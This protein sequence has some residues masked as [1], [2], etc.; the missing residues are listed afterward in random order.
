MKHFHIKILTYSLIY[1]LLAPSLL[2]LYHILTTE[3]TL[4]YSSKISFNTA[5][6]S[7]CFVFHKKILSS[8][9]YTN[10]KV[11]YTKDIF[12]ELFIDRIPRYIKKDLQKCLFLRA[13]PC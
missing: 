4:Q 12:S 8:F 3:H 6:D 13:P 7:S 10:F 2:K 11:F 9:T 5:D 1:L